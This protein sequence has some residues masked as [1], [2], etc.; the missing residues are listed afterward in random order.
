MRVRVGRYQTL[1]AR[2]IGGTGTG[3]R[4]RN[5]WRAQR[6]ERPR[7]AAMGEEHEQTAGDGEILFEMQELVAIAE[8]G[9][10]ENR[11]GEAKARE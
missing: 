4:A 10:K 8:L 11:G 5:P 7:A 6:I 3:L 2:D 9:V 1:G